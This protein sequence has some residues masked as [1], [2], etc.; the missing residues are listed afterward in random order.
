MVD[1][2][3]V[4]ALIPASTDPIDEAAG[5][6]KGVHPL[7]RCC[8]KNTAKKSKMGADSPV[9]GLDSFALLAY[10]GGES[11]MERVRAVLHEAE[12][13]NCRVVAS[14]INLGEAAYIT[15]RERGLTRAQAILGL[16][17]QLPIEILPASEEM[18]FS[19]AHI[20]ANYLVAY[21]DAFAIAAAQTLRG[22][23]LTGDPEFRAVEELIEVEWL[24][25]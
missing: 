5:M 10:L 12:A 14:I 2:G 15:E 4:L 3:G 21:A 16:I 24:A 20:K 13:G 25:R 6:F 18:V 1:Y 8:W 23:A 17:L 11:G 22:T 7:P 19:A 9:Y